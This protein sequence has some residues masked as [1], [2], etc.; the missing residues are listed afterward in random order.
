MLSFFLKSICSTLLLFVLLLP[1]AS[2]SAR[3]AE[4]KPVHQGRNGR[5]VYLPD[6]NGNTIPDFSY[7]GFK[8]GGVRL[9]QAAVKRIVQP[10][11]GD[12][13]ARIQQA[14]DAVS[15]LPPN[16]NGLRG[17]VL[18]KKGRY[19]ISGSL[20][21]AQSGVVLQG[22]GQG[23]DGTVLLATGES[24]RTLL[25]IGGKGKP[26]E[27]PDTRREITDEYV[28]V[29]ARS[30]HVSDATGFKVG[31]TVIGRRPS[32]AN[33]IP[34][35]G[36]DRLPPRSDGQPITQWKPGSKDLLFDRVITAINGRRITID[37]PLTNAFEKKYGGGTIYKYDFPGRIELVGIENL[38]GVSEYK[39]AEDEKHAMDFIVMDVVTNAWVRKITAAH[40]IHSAVTVEE[41]GKWIT[42][43][44]SNCLDPI[45]RIR[46]C[47]RYPFLLSGQLTL[48]QRCY[49]RNGRHDFVNG[50]TVAG[51]NVFL[52]CSSEKAHADSGPHHRWATGT[53]F[54]NVHVEGNAINI[55]NR[56]NLGTGHGWAGANVVLWNCTAD[57]IICEQPPTA[58]NWAIG[59]RTP[60]RSGDAF[61]ESL[62]Q[63][64]HPR[65][66]YLKQLEDRRGAAAVI[67]ISAK[68]SGFG[69]L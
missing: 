53:L 50:S 5:L 35:L 37:A 16:R 49:A 48:V 38:R 63:M 59:C 55:R 10:G 13:G 65:S 11:D 22:E 14:I 46:G 44:G 66:L 27:V 47:R 20:R 69:K 32:T 12:D 3:R 26:R 1:G 30:F 31:D 41:W 15:D 19:E 56:G 7:C 42:I 36:M 64:V 52:D 28:P 62:G 58:Q 23:E 54:D 24:K 67:N 33:W 6:E 17:A 40:F 45:S 18:L 57:S 61:W 51:P 8:A 25:E 39:G 68:S 9:P 29:G 21:I 43:E 60:Q 4:S 34:D 2:L